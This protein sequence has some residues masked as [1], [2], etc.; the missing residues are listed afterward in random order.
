M[1]KFEYITFQNKLTEQK[2]N[3]LGNDGWELVTHSVVIGNGFGTQ[4]YI[5]KREKK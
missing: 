2:L 3:E 1:R 5:F 4:Y